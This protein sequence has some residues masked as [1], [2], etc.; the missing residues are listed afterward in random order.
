MGD[1]EWDHQL[2]AG[3]GRNPKLWRNSMTIVDK[4][5]AH[6]L[7]KLR[8]WMAGNGGVNVFHCFTRRDMPH[9]LKTHPEKNHC[10]SI[11][12]SRC[13]CKNWHW[14]FFISDHLLFEK[15]WFSDLSHIMS[16]SHNSNYCNP[17]MLDR[18]IDRSVQTNRS[19]LK[20]IIMDGWV[21]SISADCTWKDQKPLHD[22]HGSNHQE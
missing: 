3:I 1:K 5:S 21:G 4:D 8:P 16:Q 20:Q 14:S 9:P 17:S 19:T 12:R 11:P 2:M 7:H 6:T 18:K 10:R 22:L 13:T 15:E